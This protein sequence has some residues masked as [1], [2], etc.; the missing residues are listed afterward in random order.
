MVFE[1]IPF[2]RMCHCQQS[3]RTIVDYHVSLDLNL[4][5]IVLSVVDAELFHL[6]NQVAKSNLRNRVSITGHR[7]GAIGGQFHGRQA[8]QS[9]AVSQN[10]FIISASNPDRFVASFRFWFQESSVDAEGNFCF[11]AID[12]RFAVVANFQKHQIFVVQLTVGSHLR[13]HPYR[14]VSVPGVDDLQSFIGQRHQRI[15]RML[16][17][18]DQLHRD[19]VRQALGARLNFRI[20]GTVSLVLCRSSALLNVHR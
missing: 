2:L 12:F 20:S 18:S 14:I 15:Q 7:K 16:S 3:T 1:V 9:C 6:H 5:F 10:L 4:A 19:R 8:K 13:Q 11:D 17:R